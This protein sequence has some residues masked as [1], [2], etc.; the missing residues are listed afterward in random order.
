MQ[1][2]RAVIK[3]LQ[4]IKP[5]ILSLLQDKGRV[6]HHRLGLTTGGP[7]DTDSFHWANRLCGN[8]DNATAIEI[9]IGGLELISTAS[10][11]I[12][13]TGA[14]MPL[15]ING[16][17][18]ELWRNHRINSGDRIQLGFSQAGCRAYLAVAGGL[19]I[20]PV[21]GSS[22]TVVR[23]GIGGLNGKPL[24]KNDNLLCFDD[25]TFSN[26]AN[27][28]V[29]TNLRPLHFQLFDSQRLNIQ[30]HASNKIEL[31]VIPSFQQ[32]RFSREQLQLFFNNTYTI[33]DQYNRMGYR[34]NGPAIDSGIS[35]MLSEGICLGAIQIPGDGQPIILLNDRQTIG[36]Y[37]KIG[38]VL[39]LDLN[40]LAQLQAGA[41]VRFSPIS[42]EQAQQL[43]RQHY[44]YWQH[45]QPVP[46]Q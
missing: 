33:S 30:A 26:R 13:V 28:Q 31:R 4:V 38:T 7:L 9:T 43:V 6:G 46:V 11:R 15:T 17:A 12:A 16:M 24:Q 42:V 2:W 22:A 10:T 25:T 40:R 20:A 29:P 36:G 41:E 44:Q 45:V 37:P 34:L 14:A 1:W 5:G 21:F 27:L 32:D 19:Q 18:K 23:E 35:S 8:S 3:K 39:S